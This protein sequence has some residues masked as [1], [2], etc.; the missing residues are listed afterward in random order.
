MAPIGRR[1]V[2]RADAPR[3]CQR[4]AATDGCSAIAGA[5]VTNRTMFGY[6]LDGWRVIARSGWWPLKAK[7]FFG[8]PPK[9]DDKKLKWIYETVTQKN[10]LQLKFEFALWTRDG[11][12]N[13]QGQIL[14]LS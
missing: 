7:L 8:R 14:A 11:C 2:Q 12:A 9:L 3:L 6:V 4:R 13:H 5:V 1:L 10:P